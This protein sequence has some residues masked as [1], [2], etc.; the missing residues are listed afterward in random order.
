MNYL[1]Y[2]LESQGFI[3]RCLTTKTYTKSQQF[4]K[5]TLKGKVNEWLKYG[6]SIHENP[7]RKEFINHRIGNLP[8]FVSIEKCKLHNELQVFDEKRT[9]EMYFPF[10]NVGVD[11]SEFYN[12]PTYLRCYSYV[13]LY[14]NEKRC[15][16]WKRAVELLSG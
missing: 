11:F 8:E 2:P 12:I 5:V 13:E 10:G 1:T 6:F 16:M 7:C 15:F 3:N 9:F 14:S 4:D